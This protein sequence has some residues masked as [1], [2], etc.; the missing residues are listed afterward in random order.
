MRRRSTY[1]VGLVGVG[2][3]ALVASCSGAD[4]Q[5][6]PGAD[7]AAAGDTSTSP[8]DSSPKDDAPVDVPDGAIDAGLDAADASDGACVNMTTDALN[9]GVCG[10]SCV[11]GRTC[12]AGRCTPAWQPLATT[13]V[14]ASRERHSA[15]AL[16]TKY[17]ATG[18]TV[19]IGGVGTTTASAYDLAT[20]TWSA[21]ASLGTQRC[22][23]EMVS[24]GAKLFAY[25]GLTDCGNGAAIGPALEES[26]GAAWSAV[27]PANAPKTRYNF[28]MTWTGTEMMIYGGGDDTLPAN[29]TGARLAPG[30][31]WVD[32]TCPLGG[33][34]RGGYYT[35][36]RDGPVVRLFGGGAFGNAPAGLAYDLA[37]KTWAAWAVPAGGPAVSEM[38]QRH[39]DDGRRIY[40]VKE[41]AVCTDPPT[42]IVY[43]RKTQTWSSDL[44]TPPAGL[45]ARGAA[46]WVGAELVV[47]SGNCG[48]AGSTVGGRYQP[49]AIAP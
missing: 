45:L 21:Y 47:W 13:N 14:P 19:T 38:P 33:C 26:A 34:E 30:G 9:C 40:F 43:D 3:V 29:A 6:G 48:G 42:L 31:A 49:P 39:A 18:G 8:G 7:D 36:F 10:Y 11:H 12:A 16:G 27:S 23:H 15:A 20:D 4:N 5:V 32:T 22:A 25:G 37:A 44:A 35:L 2:A 28:A 1:A 17:V 46:A 41:P 24:S